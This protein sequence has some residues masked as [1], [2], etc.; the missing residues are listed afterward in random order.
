MTTENKTYIAPH[1]LK[2]SHKLWGGILR[3]GLAAVSIVLA[4][5][6]RLA[7]EAWVGTGL[8][9]YITFYPVIM[10]VALLA[11]V[12]PGLMA[13][14]LTGLIVTYWVLPPTGEFA[15]AFPVDRLGLVFFCG[16]GI[17]MS[18][19]A[20]FYRRNRNKAAAYDREEAM[21][22]S[23]REN[24][25]FANLLENASQSFA[26]GYCDGRL[27]LHN[28]AYEQLTGYTAAELRGLDWAATLTPLEWRDM[29]K[30]KLD[31]L[32]ST[33]RPVRYEKE[34]VRKDGSRVPVDLLVHL[35]RDSEGKPEYYYAFVTD[36]TER[37]Q[38]EQ[39]LQRSEERYR[40]LFNTL[41]E[42]F[43]VVEVLFDDASV[44][45][46]YR[47]LEVNPAFEAQTGLKNAQGKLMR[48]I[49]PD[50]EQHWFELYG[51]VAM[52]GESARF[53][54]EAKSL[55]RWFDVYAYRVD[56][57][58]ERHVAIIFNDITIRRQAEQNVLHHVADLQAKNAEL[59][60]ANRVMVGRELRMIELKKEV[61]EI[62]KCAGE[63][64]R[65]K[66]EGG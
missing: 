2:P 45:V 26:V 14:A 6:L 20:E 50:H 23:H 25:F 22:E 42:G 17:F 4:M 15:I 63:P 8:A 11:G 46:D 28:R 31:E 37:K 19:I 48:E 66:G 24:A 32:H 7:L 58:E 44:P 53:E 54:N 10:A 36:I 5:G 41:M 13:T 29:E 30:Q 21:R 16:M 61:N 35:M 49:A 56:R 55:K 47:F 12:G 33:G 27:G 43:C 9:T 18:V 60:R 62:C 64:Q 59:E 57:P 3:Y 40:M 39:A 52:T 51:K 38:A 65:Y 34:Y 1:P